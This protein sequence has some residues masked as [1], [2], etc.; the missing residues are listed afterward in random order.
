MDRSR[1]SNRNG[2]GKKASRPGIIGVDRGKPI[3][4]KNGARFPGDR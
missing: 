4:T 3:M 2:K 1:K